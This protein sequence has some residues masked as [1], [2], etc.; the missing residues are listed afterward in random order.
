M[1]RQTGQRHRFPEM[2]SR[3]CHNLMNKIRLTLI[4]SLNQMKLRKVSGQKQLNKALLHNPFVFLQNILQSLSA[5]RRRIH[6]LL[7]P[8]PLI[9]HTIFMVQP[10]KRISGIFIHLCR[11]NDRVLRLSIRELLRQI[12]GK[13]KRGKKVQAGTGLRITEALR[14]M[15]LPRKDKCNVSLFHMKKLLINSD[16]KCSVQDINDFH[17]IMDVRSKVYRWPII[18]LQVVWNRF[19]DWSHYVPLSNVSGGCTALPVHLAFLFFG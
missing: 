4:R 3:V 16:F 7:K 12:T 19:I 14:M 18:Y 1:L 8:C 5:D 13:R 15:N 6:D 2:R 9:I 17:Q 10:A 11:R